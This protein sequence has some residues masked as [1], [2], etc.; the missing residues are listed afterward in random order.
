M[1]KQITIAISG[2]MVLLF[3]GCNPGNSPKPLKFKAYEHNPVLTAGEPGSWDELFV[4]LPRV[5]KHDSL[6]YL[7]YSG[8]NNSGKTGIGLATSED[9]FHYTKCEEK[10]V[11]NTTGKGQV[12]SLFCPD[13]F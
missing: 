6:F 8:S 3:L 5:V 1:K 2:F 7:F 12:K 4:I 9:G 11:Y 13:F 10:P